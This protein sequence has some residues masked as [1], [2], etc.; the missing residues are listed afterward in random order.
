[1]RLTHE[2]LAASFVKGPFYTVADD[3]TSAGVDAIEPSKLSEPFQA[4]VPRD[5]LFSPEYSAGKLLAV[6]EGL[7]PQDSGKVFAWDGSEVPC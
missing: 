3:V 4:R 2:L 5:K 6:L 1:M 7:S